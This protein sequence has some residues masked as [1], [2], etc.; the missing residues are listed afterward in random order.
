MF[1]G[2]CFG[3]LS[4]YIQKLQKLV[5]W[6]LLWGRLRLNAWPRKGLRKEI[7]VEEAK[8]NFLAHLAA[9]VIVNTF[10][11]FINLLTSPK[12]LWVHWVILGWGMDLAFHFI[13][14]RGDP[15]DL[16]RGTKPARE[17]TKTKKKNKLR[18]KGHVCAGFS[19]FLNPS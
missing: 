13:F 19:F 16:T 3:A 6:W 8:R 1:F 7:E 18:K 15:D 12:A 4:I 11:F 14:P 17:N 2:W 5:G 10:L 9:Y